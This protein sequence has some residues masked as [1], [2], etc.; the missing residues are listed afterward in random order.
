[1]NRQ[2]S[3]ATHAIVLPARPPI[4]SFTHGTMVRPTMFQPFYGIAHSL[5]MNDFSTFILRM[6][7]KHLVT[8]IMQAGTLESAATAVKCYLGADVGTQAAMV[9]A[10][11]QASLDA[12]LMIPLHK[13]TATLHSHTPLILTLIND[14]DNPSADTVLALCNVVHEP[15]C[16]QEGTFVFMHNSMEAAAHEWV[17]AVQPRAVPPALWTWQLWATCECPQ[18]DVHL[19]LD[20]ATKLLLSQWLS[21]LMCCTY[22]DETGGASVRLRQRVR[23]VK[24]VE[25]VA[26]SHRVAS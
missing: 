8:V 13:P 2:L 1:M 21:C 23:R 17:I 16:Q 11:L 20:A 4:L 18:L 14:V 5:E 9:H 24:H 15:T 26:S 22:A 19:G 7:A 25:R 6:E 10:T 3:N 12:L